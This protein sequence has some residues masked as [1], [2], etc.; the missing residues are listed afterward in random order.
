MKLYCLTPLL[1]V[2]ASVT[3]MAKKPLYSH[4]IQHYIFHHHTWMDLVLIP[5][6]VE[7]SFHFFVALV[8]VPVDVDVVA[9]PVGG[10]AVD[11]VEMKSYTSID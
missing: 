7:I 1:L 8:A 11:V 3:K 6:L 4:V 5:L 9:V 2:V 10:D